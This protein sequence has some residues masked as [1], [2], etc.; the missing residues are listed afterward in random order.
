MFSV[1]NLPSLFATIPLTLG[2]M[3]SE[4]LVV[5][6]FRGNRLGATLRLDLPKDERPSRQWLEQ[7]AGYVARAEPEW[8]GIAVYTDGPGADGFPPRKQFAEDVA[9]HFD[10]VAKYPVRLAGL[11]TAE[12]WECYTSGDHG[13]RVESEFTEY[14]AHEIANGNLKDYSIPKGGDPNPKTEALIAA[15]IDRNMPD[16]VRLFNLNRWDEIVSGAELRTDELEQLIA[17]TADHGTR[18]GMMVHCAVEHGAPESDYPSILQGIIPG[19]LNEE[20][21]TYALGL[22]NRMLSITTHPLLRA[23]LLAMAGWLHWLVGRGTIAVEHYEEAL[24]GVPDHRLSSLMREFV[25]RGYVSAAATDPRKW[26]SILSA[27]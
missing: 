11:I 21:H 23:E 7:T 9:A 22:L 13:P 24:A 3:P 17:W 18:D 10:H 26:D 27:N 15:H 6:M 12:E 16:A 2:Y 14:T 19:G 1:S 4:S 25:N 5:M 8:V 20:R